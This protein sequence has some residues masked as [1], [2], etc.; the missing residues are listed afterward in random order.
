MCIP[1]R[2]RKALRTSGL[3]SSRLPATLSELPPLQTCTIDCSQRAVRAHISQDHS[4]LQAC[5]SGTAWAS[6]QRCPEE[7]GFDEHTERPDGPHPTGLCYRPLLC[8][9]QMVNNLCPL[10][11]PWMCCFP[12]ALMTATLCIVN[13]EKSTD[14]AE[15]LF[16]QIHL[17]S[18]RTLGL[19]EHPAAS[20]AERRPLL[21]TL[22]KG[23]STRKTN[24]SSFKHRGSEFK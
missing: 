5:C 24:T 8:S 6:L 4:V 3:S 15:R 7:Q 16:A 18:L 10:N 12:V 22:A 11:M 9:A 17:K 1:T 20:P 23:M 13:A 21:P 19:G 2:Q 14:K